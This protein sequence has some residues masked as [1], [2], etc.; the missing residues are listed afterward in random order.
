MQRR[1]IETNNSVY[2]SQAGDASCSSCHGQRP[3]AELLA[4]LDAAQLAGDRLQAVALIEQ[5]YAVLDIGH[6][7]TT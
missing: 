4:A 2:I 6:A 3:K 7:M 1:N 5:I